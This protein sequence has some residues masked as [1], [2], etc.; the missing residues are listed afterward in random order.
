MASRKTNPDV[1]ARVGDFV[2]ATKASWELYKE[3]F[4]HSQQRVDALIGRSSLVFRELRTALGNAAMLEVAKLLDE[5]EQTLSLA[6]GVAQ[7]P[8]DDP[9]RE[10]FAT[11]L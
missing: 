1:V 8:A 2:G 6:Q 10:V 9:Q 4:S 11:R 7:L 5:N 3:F